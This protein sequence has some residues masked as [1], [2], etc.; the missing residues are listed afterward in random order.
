MS[1]RQRTEMDAIEI[2]DF[3]ATQ[4]T[5][6]LSMAEENNSYAVPVSF[7]FDE[8][9]QN[10]YLR[11]GYGSNST[12]RA[13]VDAVNR[14]SFLVYAAT[15]DGWKSVLARG[16]LEKLSEGSLD[17]ETIKATRNLQ[18]PYFQV[19]DEGSK[20]LEFEFVRIDTTELTGI[21]SGKSY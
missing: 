15:E 17:D 19:F 13:F 21:I 8:R 6:V 20:D 12:K 16:H 1:F 18:I 7:A 14:A 5:G 3:L 2:A 11:L 4:Q 10:V 9:E